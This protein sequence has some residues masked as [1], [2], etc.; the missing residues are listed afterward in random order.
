MIHCEIEFK[1]HN[2]IP[3]LVF[4]WTCMYVQFQ[5]HEKYIQSKNQPIYD[6]LTPEIVDHVILCKLAT[7]LGCQSL[8]ESEVMKGK[9]MM[10]CKN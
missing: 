5:S 8:N 10:F 3:L 6:S 1:S 2:P 9:E 7:W 4:N